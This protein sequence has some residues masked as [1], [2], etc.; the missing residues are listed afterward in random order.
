MRGYEYF[1]EP[2]WILT[3]LGR[4]FSDPPTIDEFEDQLDYSIQLIKSS[5]HNALFDRSPIDF[6]VMHGLLHRKMLRNLILKDGNPKWQ[7]YYRL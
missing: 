6:W 1:D 3:E 5:S 7:G 4:H 2:Y